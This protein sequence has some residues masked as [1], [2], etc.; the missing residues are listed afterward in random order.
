MTPAWNRWSTMFS[1]SVIVIVSIAI[2]FL[3]P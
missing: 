1:L 3:Q 2:A